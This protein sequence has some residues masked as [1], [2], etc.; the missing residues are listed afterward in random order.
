MID[1][2]EIRNHRNYKKIK[3]L[4]RFETGIVTKTCQTKNTGTVTQTVKRGLKKENEI[5][6]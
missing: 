5:H 6:C 3:G 1:R 2:D 4:G